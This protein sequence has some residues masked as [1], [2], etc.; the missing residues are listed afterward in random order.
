MLAIGI[1]K[2]GK[3]NVGQRIDTAPNLQLDRT[4]TRS[5]PGKRTSNINGKIYKIHFAELLL[6]YF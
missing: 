4:K 1:S 3:Q 6:A 5:D 2:R